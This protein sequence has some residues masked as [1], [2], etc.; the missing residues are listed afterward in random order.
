MPKP[1]TM[2][3]NTL[4]KSRVRQAH[5]TTSYATSAIDGKPEALDFNFENVFWLYDHSNQIRL[6]TRK[7]EEIEKTNDIYELHILKSKHTKSHIYIY[8]R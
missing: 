5:S 7:S 1:R 8:S 2:G 4:E 6:S 3:A